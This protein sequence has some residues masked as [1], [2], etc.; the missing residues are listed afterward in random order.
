MTTTLQF[1]EQRVVLDNI[2]W[3]LYE[4]LLFAHRDR[5]AP[6]FTY[7]KGQLEIMSPSYEHERL[8]DKITLLVN[9][10]AE[11]L[12]VNAQGAGST[13]FRRV[14]LDRGF[15]PDACFYFENRHRIRGKKEIDLTIDPPPDLVIEIDITNPSL[16]KLSIMAEIRVPEV[17]H[18]S[19][20]NWRILK[21]EGMQF[22]QAPE[23]AALPGLT[24]EAISRLMEESNALEPLAWTR[25]VRQSLGPKTPNA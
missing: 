19:K 9:I 15:E 22:K 6:R 3:E 11:K 20:N 17:W 13:T 4:S 5:S 7:D 25:F 1:P 10:V 21:L 16:N 24:S 18:Y 14:D 2:S 23:S 8:K 12:G